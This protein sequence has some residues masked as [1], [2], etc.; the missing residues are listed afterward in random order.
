MFLPS[1]L[2]IK[3]PGTIFSL[4]R[5]NRFT[6]LMMELIRNKNTPFIFEW[7][8][9]LF[10]VVV[11]PFWTNDIHDE[12]D[13]KERYQETDGVLRQNLCH[14]I[15][16]CRCK[17]STSEEDSGDGIYTQ[18]LQIT[19]SYCPC[20]AERWAVINSTRTCLCRRWLPFWCS[21]SY[22]NDYNEAH[23]ARQDEKDCRCKDTNKHFSWHD[24]LLFCSNLPEEYRIEANT[25]EL[26][27]W[28]T[29]L[30]WT[31]YCLEQFLP[32]FFY[33]CQFSSRR[34]R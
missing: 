11:S 12:H 20:R 26:S 19:I 1:N 4:M 28:Y 24:Y 2:V 29:D 14:V 15:C 34:K 7:G 17:D 10:S 16:I 27:P 9:L 6:Q 5:A 32:Y 23:D 3:V 21:R 13:Y 30:Q 31:V 33:W 22:I 8:A 18:P 25:Q